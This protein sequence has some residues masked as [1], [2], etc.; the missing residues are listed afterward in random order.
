[1]G[2]LNVSPDSFSDGGRFLAVDAA[3]AHATGMRNEGADLI[4]IGGE[5]TRAGVA[6]GAHLINDV[7]AGTLDPALL[8]VVASLGVPVCL[9]HL[10]IL[11]GPIGW[12]RAVLPAETNVVEVIVA[13]LRGRIDV[14]RAAGISAENI[15]ID[16]GF[17]FGKS[18]AQNVALVRGLGEIKGALEDLPLL[19][20]TSRKSTL[21]RLVGEHAGRG[22]W[23]R[24]RARP[25]R[26]L[27]GARCARRRRHCPRW[28]AGKRV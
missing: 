12:S 27:H 4:D 22:P 5:S 25:R 19:L 8:P 23:G 17:G 10:P 2:V 6:A 16:P 15:I 7:S 14:A 13:F 11:P 9:M 3:L 28:R 18:V 21:A 26:W 24:H 20:G 1:M